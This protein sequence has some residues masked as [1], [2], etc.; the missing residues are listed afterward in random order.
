MVFS[1][2][3]T[4]GVRAEDGIPDA[5]IESMSPNPA[6]SGETVSLTGNEAINGSFKLYK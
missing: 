4:K 6:E 1:A 3:G 2:Y 5:I